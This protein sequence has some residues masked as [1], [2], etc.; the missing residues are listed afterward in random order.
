MSPNY[1]SRHAQLS[2]QILAALPKSAPA[3]LRKFAEAFF[4]QSTVDELEQLTSARAADIAQFCQRASAKRKPGEWQIIQESLALKGGKGDTRR[5]RMLIV[6]DDMPFLVDSLTN[7]LSRLGLSVHLIVHP[8]LSVKRDKTGKLTEFGTER[9][10]A[11]FAHESLIYFELP[12]LSEDLD[13]KTIK[14]H[15]DRVLKKVRVVTSDWKAMDATIGTLAKTYEKHCDKKHKAE[16]AEVTS[17]LNW[18]QNKNFVFLGY[19]E[20]T[21]TKKKSGQDELVLD[22]KTAKGLYRVASDETAIEFS[23]K[24]TVRALFSVQKSSEVCEVHRPGAMDYIALR[25]LDAKGNIIGEIRILGLFTSVVY[26]QSTDL[27]PFIRNKVARILDYSGFDRHGHSGKSLRTIIEFLPRDELFQIGEDELF[28]MVMGILAL[29]LKPE[30]RLF[31]RHDTFG[32]FVSCLVYVPRERFSTNIRE[33]VGKILSK[34]YNGT[35]GAFYTQMT[36]SPLARL[37]VIIN[38]TPGAVPQADQG[39]LERTIS[40]LVNLW[41]DA[42][43]EALVAQ[44]DEEKGIALYHRYAE[45]FQG[46]YTNTH[47]AQSAAFDIRKAEACLKE[48]GLALEIFRRDGEDPDWVHVKAYSTHVD[49][50]LSEILPLLDQMGATI[51]DVTPYDITPKNAAPILLR[52]FTL[53]I[54]P[55]ALMDLSAERERIETAMTAVWRGQ[56]SNDPL[57][58]LVFYAGLTIRDIE[59][60]QLYTR[61]LKQAGFSYS[62]AFMAQALRSH[63]KLTRLLIDLFGARFDPATKNRDDAMAKIREALVQGLENVTNLAEDTVIR[64]IESLIMASLRVNYYQRDKAGQFKSYVSVKFRSSEVPELPLPVP[65]AEI[66]VTSMR[67][68]GIHLRGGSVARGGLRWSDRPEDFRTE[69]LGLMKAQQVKNAVIVPQGAKGGFVLRKPPEG[70]DAFMAEGIEC[71]KEFLR[72]LL[73][74][75]DNIVGDKVVRP[76]EVVCHDGEDPYLVVAADK[77]TATFSDIANSVSAEYGFWLADAFASGGSAGYDHKAMGITAAGAWVSVERHFRELGMSTKEPFTAIGIG[78]MAGDVFGNGLLSVDTFK[79]IAAFN[80]K[81]IFIDPTPDPKKSFEERKRLFTTPRTQWS[82]YKPSLISTGGGIYERSAKSITLSK[83]AKAALGADKSTYSP[84]QLI[85]VI[86]KAQ[87]DLLWNGGIGTYV[88][89][90][91]ETHEQVGDRANN[92]VRINGADLRCKVI[93]EGGNLGFTQRG[94]IEYARNG[95][96]INTDAIDNSGGVDCS[97]HEVNIKIALGGAGAKRK[98]NTTEKRNTLLKN[99]TDEVGQL[100]LKDNRL[101]TQ[102]ITIAEKQ[103]LALIESAGSFMSEM[104]R[105]GLL[106]R[107]VEYLPTEKQLGEMRAARQGFTRPELA[108]LM[109]YSKQSLFAELQQSTL[110]DAP[111]FEADL[112]RYFPKEMQKGFANDIRAHRLRREIV[113]TMITN[114]IVNRTGITFAYEL[115][116]ETGLHA[117]DIAQAYVVTRDAFKLRELWADIE[118]LDGVVDAA[119]QSELFTAVNGFIEHN[120]RWFLQHIPQPMQIDKVMEQFAAGI[121][122]FVKH[123]DTII[124]QTLRKSYEQAVE[125]LIKLNIPHDVARKVASLEILASACDVVE[126]ANQ[127]G[128]PV[129]HVGRVYFELGAELKL[130]WLRRTARTL[131]ADTHWEQLAITALATELYQ[132][133]KHLTVRVLKRKK[134]AA[135]HILVSGWMEENQESLGRYL[136]SMESLKSQQQTANYAMLIVALRQVQWIINV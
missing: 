22:K 14:Q 62:H 67:V 131:K 6:N 104:E 128:L 60:L 79:L 88:K 35:L 85:Q 130:G 122:T 8:V 51:V 55:V 77:G 21:V 118:M 13:T 75:T 121:T 64:R 119:V 48:D 54:P 1:A 100:V 82:D 129:E 58:A 46:D 120:C 61:Y 65:H 50:A 103:G 53:R 132:A 70:R 24:H 32:R 101:Q 59:I 23:P 29:E 126:A 80:H 15:I 76:K 117:P 74:I 105:E 93:G 124:T 125:G 78:D 135:P 69:V 16:G 10:Q 33:Q 98:L 107:A 38:T 87:V 94:R 11:G 27:I 136:A 113:A 106:N 133:Q 47:S 49:S 42:L 37:H 52:D 3:S 30:V 91:T 92:A 81:H 114:S 44:F 71:Y 73:D 2:K 108:V 109:A 5:T 102:A 89:A 20:Y 7:L 40:D 18:L 63:P 43:K 34:A 99:M 123:H 31:A 127:T 4:G 41:Q 19:G 86:L 83:E 28:S 17:F 115:I 95:G 116:R 57:N 90:T 66:F 25:R 68:D 56:T 9:K 12:P 134:G 84:D 45:A 112:L 111:Y 72:G 96:K 39:T 110:L 36:D 26:Y 97:D